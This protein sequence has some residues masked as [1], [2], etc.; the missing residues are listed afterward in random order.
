MDS[1]DLFLIGLAGFLIILVI[2]AVCLLGYVILYNTSHVTDYHNFDNITYKTD[3]TLNFGLL[4]PKPICQIY[5][6][7]ALIINPNN[8]QT[9]GYVNVGSKAIS[10]IVQYYDNQTD[11][12]CVYLGGP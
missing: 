3:Y 4:T 8:N 6:I 11:E 7:Q 10:Y 5:W 9:E 12:K 1:N 2:L